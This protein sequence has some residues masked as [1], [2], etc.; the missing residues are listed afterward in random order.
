M[1]L[2][3]F[4]GSPLILSPFNMT[5]LVCLTDF[6]GAVSLCFEKEETNLL[7]NR[8]RSISNEKLV[9]FKNLVHGYLVTGGY[10]SVNLVSIPF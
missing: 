8:P 1:L 2:N 10:Y 3:V 6:G 9:D 5:I 7:K 4:G